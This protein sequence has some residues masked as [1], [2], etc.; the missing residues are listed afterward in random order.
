[1]SFTDW[2]SS[3]D[4]PGEPLAAGE[5]RELRARFRTRFHDPAA[6]KGGPPWLSM[7]GPFVRTLTK[8]LK[9]PIVR[10]CE[11]VV[12]YLGAHSMYRCTPREMNVWAAERQTWDTETFGVFPVSMAWCIVYS[13]NSP[14]EE[15]S[16][17]VYGDEEMRTIMRKS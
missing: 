16:A 15:D 5:I 10:E 7:R 4:L 14:N 6:E 3:K 1:M 17:L 9:H 12:V 11:S 2:S 13:V 8:V